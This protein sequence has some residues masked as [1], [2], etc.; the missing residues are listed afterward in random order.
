MIP[1]LRASPGPEPRAG[2]GSDVLRHR[3]P[4]VA[5]AAM[6][7]LVSPGRV[8]GQ[9]QTPQIPQSPT[10]QQP[11]QPQQ[12]GNTGPQDPAALQ[13][14]G[15]PPLGAP[16]PGSQQ[17]DPFYS[18]SPLSSLR[19]R[20]ESRWTEPQAQA[21][22]GFPV[23]PSQLAGYGSYPG[24][25]LPTL[26]VGL[27]PG[28]APDEPPGWPAW[29][30]TRDKTALPFAPE[31]ALLIRHADR[32]WQRA[33]AEEP[34]VPLFFHDKLRT[35]EAGAA[36]EVRQT[37]EFE[38]LLHKSTR[39]IA[40][41]P[42]GVELVKMTA[43]EVQLRIVSLSWLRIVVSARDHVI[44][45]PGGSSLQIAAPAAAGAA[46]TPTFLPLPVPMT[47]PM[48]GV[49]DL[50]LTRAAEPAWLSGRATLTNLGSTDVRWR[51]AGGEVVLPPS[52][53]LT[54]FL[55]S[56][57]Q[58]LPAGLEVSGASSELVD[59]AMVCRAQGPGRA[60]W[61]GAGFELPAGAALRLDPQQGRPFDP[62][63]RRADEKAPTSR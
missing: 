51:H 1:L 32:V 35:L 7:L 8:V 9:I 24:F 59:G 28:P 25:G 20:M 52:H 27:P 47:A 29:A 39:L 10:Q 21:F 23:F 40:R 26:G 45:L 44:D 17:A 30:R 16:L 37:G 36:V 6:A 33:N 11:Q 55:A 61:C 34:F 43:A 5:M 42:S 56:G 4:V 49:T 57:Q 50:V 13:Q 31:L 63:A 41:G 15:L 53:R 58:Q 2:A 48:P 12:P 19:Q 3:A 46:G 18:M 14:P 22:Q 38:L 54:F 62:P 60:T